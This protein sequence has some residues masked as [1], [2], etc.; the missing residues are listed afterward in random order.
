MG[1]VCLL[2]Y[3]LLLTR[4]PTAVVGIQVTRP[5]NHEGY[6]FSCRHDLNLLRLFPLAFHVQVAKRADVVDFDVLRCAAHLA[7]VG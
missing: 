7:G 4:F 2:D 1:H 3:L 6:A 5:A